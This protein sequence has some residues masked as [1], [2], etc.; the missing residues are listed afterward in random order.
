MSFDRGINFF[1]KGLGLENE[2]TAY[3]FPRLVMFVGFCLWVATIGLSAYLVDH[4]S[5]YTRD[6]YG[7]VVGLTVTTGL[8][9]AFDLFSGEKWITMF[10]I[11]LGSIATFFSAGKKSFFYCKPNE[12]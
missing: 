8:T 7:A 6:Y 1:K 11:A 3:L 4:E 5:G 2:L 9:T 10:T 12:I